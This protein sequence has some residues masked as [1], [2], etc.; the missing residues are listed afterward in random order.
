ML[1]AFDRRVIA[2]WAQGTFRNDRRSPRIAVVGNCQSRGIAYGMK[3]L[4]PNG[5]VDCYPLVQRSLT[6]VERLAS[7]LKN[8]DFTFC[9]DFPVGFVRGAIPT[10]CGSASGA[11]RA[12]R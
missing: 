10:R 2:A 3:L 11:S 6:T 4:L 1:S 5:A 7:I 12:F 8:Y 9:I